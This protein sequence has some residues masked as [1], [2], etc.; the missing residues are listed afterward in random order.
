MKATDSA[1]AYAL[2]N[3][4]A[5]MEHYKQEHDME[6]MQ[7][8]KKTARVLVYLL[9]V[10]TLLAGHASLPQLPGLPLLNVVLLLLGACFI[11][12]CVGSR[13]FRLPFGHAAPY[14]GVL[15]LLAAYGA[16]S[17]LWAKNMDY[18]WNIYTYQALGV[19]AV[20]CMAAA[21]R[22][23]GQFLRFLDVLTLCYVFT[24]CVGIY[25]IFTGHFIFSPSNDQLQLKN[26]YGLWFPYV[27]FNNT[28]DYATYIILFF[29]F[30]AYTLTERL[31]G[32]WGRAAATALFAAAMF[33]MFNA[34]PRIL[35][36][37]IGLVAV[38]FY[39]C[40]AFKPG[41]GRYAR[42][43]AG[44]AAA[45]VGAVALLGGTMLI[46]ASVFASEINSINMDN[47]SVSE[48]TMLL[49]ATLRMI[50]ASHFL[51]V[52][53]GNA[54]QLMG[55][56]SASIK[57]FNVHNMTLQL[58][59]EYGILVWVPYVLMLVALLVRFFRYR[60]GAFRQDALA[61]L[62]FALVVGL[63][64]I[65]I[66][67]ADM[68]HILAVWP[69]FGLLFVCLKVLYPYRP[70]AAGEKARKL[71]FISF[72]DFGDFTSGSSVRPQRMAQAFGK[73]GY[74]VTVLSG[75]Q[76][77]KRQRWLRV[78]RVWRTLRD[79]LPD[80]CYVEPPS[81]PFFNLCDHLLLLRLW[82]NGV[83]IGLFYRDAYWK[84]ADWWGVKGFKRWGLTL[85]HRFDLIVFRIT[86]TVL[87]FPTQ[88]MA[89]LFAFPRKAVLPPAGMECSVPPHPP[90]GKALYVGGVSHFYGT[91]MLLGAFAILNEEL[92]RPVHLTVVCRKKEMGDFFEPYLGREW[93]TVLHLSGD[94]ALAP[95]YAQSDVALYPSRPDRYMDFCMPVKLFEYLSRALPVVCTDCTEA[96]AFVRENG[97]GVV[98]PYNPREYALAVAALFDDPDGLQ[99]MRAHCAEVLRTKHLWRHRAAQAAKI[100]LQARQPAPFA[101]Q[102]A[103]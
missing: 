98:T 19:A 6:R 17:L 57:P 45:G 10:A 102:P 62:C 41:A 65:G 73:L 85:M 97:V 18:S 5:G 77:R 40:M 67:S 16:L 95:L 68:T 84:F 44:M 36:F 31:R 64:V 46:K 15:I 3:G 89:D 23:R 20:L 13:R 103:D 87:F 32:L 37:A 35:Y 21:L 78:W 71:L 81:G 34:D 69:F 42:A 96:A 48:R 30:A 2:W 93:L 83:P 9:P 94:A 25:E 22:Q 90:A 52:G 7:T 59:A 79:D 26:A 99:A 70:P 76:N 47:H 33:T 49:F 1:Q 39:V 38:A 61:S 54:A 43:L 74:A 56:F 58:L 82:A 101:P 27:T 63:P 88:S 53:V 55:Y 91:D 60:G 29:P 51:G 80:F 66:A 12:Y 8:L 100:I 92:R 14:A 28:N 72:I 75:L 50:P 11:V 24:V 86:C 4:T